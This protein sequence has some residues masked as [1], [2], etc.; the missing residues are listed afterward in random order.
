MRHLLNKGC[1]VRAVV[2]SPERLPEGT[3]QHP[4]LTVTV[5]PILELSAQQMQQLVAGCD[6][7]IFALGHNMTLAGIW[8]PPFALVAESVKRVCEA[9]EAAKP[10]KP[11][12]LVLSADYAPNRCTCENVAF[13][14]N[15][16]VKSSPR[17]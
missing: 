12:R 11:V 8:G 2:R 16:T 10:P 14:L 4:N 3:A 15:R 17:P 6:S 13:R 5:A 9:V 1:N 7:V